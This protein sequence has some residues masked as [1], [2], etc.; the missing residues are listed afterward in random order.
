MKFSSFVAFEQLNT[1][2]D[3]VPP[4]SRAAAE[5]AAA[6]SSETI[7]RPQNR[8]RA[9]GAIR[10]G[11]VPVVASSAIVTAE[12]GAALNPYVPQPDRKNTRLNSSHRKISYAVFCL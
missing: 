9:N 11:T 4:F 7:R 1:P 2:N 6:A 8:S 10:S 3:V 5:T 12:M